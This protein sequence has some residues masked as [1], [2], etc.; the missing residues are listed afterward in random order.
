MEENNKNVELNKDEK[1]VIRRRRSRIE[2][3]KREKKKSKKDKKTKKTKKKW[4]RKK[5]I[6]VFSIIILFF[7]VIGVVFGTYVY[8]AD[9]NIAE[10]VLNVA[11]DVL[12]ND[13]PIFVLIL[14]I[15]DDIKT[16]LTDTIILAGYNPE[17]QQAFMLSIPRDTF[18]G[19]NEAS[20][21]GFD[22]INA[23]Y[24]K[25]VSK[26]VTAVEKLT[27]VKIDNYVIVKNTVLPSLV[28]A[29]GGEIEFDVPIDM[30]YDDKTQ[31]LHIH[32]KKGVQMID[33][34]EA[35]QLLRFRHNNDGSS[36]PAS[37]GNND[38]GRM[39]TQREFIKVVAS[40]LIK[41]NS[42]SKLKGLAEFIFSNLITDMPL[43]KAISYIPTGLKF[44]TEN[45]I[46]EQLP[47]SSGMINN[48]SFFRASAS[49]TKKVMDNLMQQ[50]GLEGKE[51]AKHYTGKITAFSSGVVVEKPEKDT[52]SDKVDS[53]QNNKNNSNT[54]SNNTTSTKNE[55]KNMTNGNSGSS[56]NTT[57]TTNNNLPND[58]KTDKNQKPDVSDSK[59]T[60]NKDN[61][62]EKQPNPSEPEITPTPSTTP[63]PSTTPT[64][65]TSPTPP[66]TP[67]PPSPGGDNQEPTE[68]N[69]DSKVSTLPKT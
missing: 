4:S 16:E 38:Y 29:V 27:G 60:E 8:K 6:I 69:N 18:V 34:N 10:A 22:K 24:Q 48:L 32:L 21:G 31:N 56:N 20:A 28:D 44:N 14:G 19:K 45:I 49:E 46:M 41:V 3:N 68:E 52:T 35:E 12:G 39:K 53:S 36:Y 64:P 13:D 11:S 66:S 63:A 30:N 40:Q 2:N 59:D 67:T 7:A 50:I 62:D 17:T 42:V 9:G 55:N 61:E 5:K 23:Q 43:S 26:T 51:L 47:G 33:R 57:N 15:S 1:T 54:A 58:D 25:D 65:S 37:Y